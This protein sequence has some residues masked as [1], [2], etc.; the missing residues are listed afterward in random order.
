MK[1]QE[2]IHNVVRGLIL[3]QNHILLTHCKGSAN[4]FL[5]GEHVEFGESLIDALVREL[6]EELG[7]HIIVSKYIGVVEH[8]WQ[9]DN[10]LYHQI[11]HVFAATPSNI[12]GLPSLISLEKH[13]EF[14][15]VEPLDLMKCNL[16]PP[17]MI[18]LAHRYS[19]GDHTFFWASTF[20]EAKS[21]E[22][23]L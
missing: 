4:T 9:N 22:G 14:F 13:L 15:W 6:D 20:A 12:N 1:T 18:E 10:R 8:K 3:V 7:I 2:Q 17:P 23:N 5:P 11:N 16:L 19:R 21:R